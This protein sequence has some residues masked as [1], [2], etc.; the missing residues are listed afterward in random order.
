[1][2]LSVDG[3]R[4]VLNGIIADRDEIHWTD[5]L[6]ERSARSLCSCSVGF[7]C[8]PRASATS[9]DCDLGRM[10]GRRMGSGDV[11]AERH[12]SG[13]RLRGSEMEVQG[14]MGDATSHVWGLFEARQGLKTD[15]ERPRDP[16]RSTGDNRAGHHMTSVGG[17]RRRAVR[18]AA[19]IG[20]S[21]RLRRGVPRVGG[22]CSV[23]APSMAP[24]PLACPPTS[25]HALPCGGP[26]GP[27]LLRELDCRGPCLS[28]LF[29]TSPHDP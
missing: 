7:W 5:S 22:V 28:A 10:P 8:S 29:T 24:R 25:W 21:L 12:T 4:V 2:E 11:G 27:Y 26:L 18:A 16:Q 14:P 15:V 6:I 9:M 19:A 17:R 13:F 1:M 23:Y 3:V 20:G